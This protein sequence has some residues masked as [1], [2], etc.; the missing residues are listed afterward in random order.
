MSTRSLVVI[1]TITILA[2]NQAGAA[3]REAAKG[4]QLFGLKGH[5]DR[6]EIPK[7]T[8]TDSC[9]SHLISTSFP[10]GRTGFYFVTTDGAAVTFSGMGTNQ[11][12]PDA[13]TA[14]QPIDQVIFGF[15]KESG[16]MKAVGLCRFANPFRGQPVKVTCR[17]ETKEGIFFGDFTTDGSKPE[18]F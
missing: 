7:A 17:A 12:K 8:L 2:A 11:I 1:L 9:G 13:D 5:C 3:G 10:N 18:V 4:P 6:L 15:K 14:V 16:S